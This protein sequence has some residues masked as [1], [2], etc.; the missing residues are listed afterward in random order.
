MEE[1]KEEEFIPKTKNKGLKIALA[2]LIV[3]GVLVGCYFLYQYKFNN[4]KSVVNKILDSAKANVVKSAKEDNNKYKFDGLLKIETNVDDTI[5]K[6]LKD[7]GIQF[8]GQI[9]YQ[10]NNGI[11]T[12]N[13]KY[14]NEKLIDVDAYYEK[15]NI[16]LLAKDLY[17]KYLKFETKTKPDTDNIDPK[18]AQ[19]IAVSIIDALKKEFNKLNIEQT[20]S[21]I[22]IDGKNIDTI[23]NKITLNSEEYTTFMKNLLNTL[24]EDKEF[25]KAMDK[26]SKENTTE[27]IDKA[28]TQITS[29][30]TK[31]VYYISFYTDKGL[32]NKNLVSVRMAIVDDNTLD[33]QVI[34]IDKISDDEMSVLISSSE[35]E[36]TARIKKNGSAINLTFGY[37]N[38]GKYVNIEFNTNY[39]KISA[40]TKP[41][42]T[43]SKDLNSITEQ[44]MNDI[45]NKLMNNKTLLKLIEDVSAVMN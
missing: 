45:Q 35:G 25:I 31:Q 28:I 4:P 19:T 24:K 20:N 9:D 18:D 14:Q 21:T 44:E 12:I 8:N 32:F 1:K 34:E 43:N 11:V 13:T 5:G 33:K 37:K 7:I 16:Y 42:V 6:L 41:D 22:T 38:E 36:V 10:G 23:E 40:I 3:V 39:E 30:N 17:D 26:V 27:S 2:A 29:N 15:D